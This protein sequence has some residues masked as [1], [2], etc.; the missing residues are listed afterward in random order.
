MPGQAQA[1]ARAHVPW[2]CSQWSGAGRTGAGA[3]KCARGVSKL[4]TASDSACSPSRLPSRPAAR[5]ADRGGCPGEEATSGARPRTARACAPSRS[6]CR[7]TKRSGSASGRRSSGGGARPAPACCSCQVR[8]RG[9][10]AAARCARTPQQPASRHACR[11]LE[12]PTLS[13]HSSRTQG[14]RTAAAPQRRQMCGNAL[15]PT[16]AAG[17]VRAS[18]SVAHLPQSKHCQCYRAQ[19]EPSRPPPDGHHAGAHADA[20]LAWVARLVKSDPI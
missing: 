2:R 11:R 9:A 17:S 15:H 14:G 6:R 5:D 18:V 4:L 1:R 7:S 16:R 20:L 13:E 3:N 8:G 19:C 10:D 12:R